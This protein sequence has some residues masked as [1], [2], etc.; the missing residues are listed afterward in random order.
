MWIDEATLK[1]QSGRGGDGIISFRHE[2]G[3]EFGGPNG[4]DGGAGGSVIFRSNETLSSLVGL[5]G[6]K[7]VKAGPGERGGATNKS[8][9]DGEDI[10]V[11]VPVGTVI[12][13]ASDGAVIADLSTPGDECMVAR[14]GR[15]GRGNARFAGPINQAPR[16]RELGEHGAALEIRLEVRLLADV[17]LVGLPNAGKSTLLSRLSAARPRIADY[18][19]TTLE[20]ML[21]VVSVGLKSFTMADLPGLIRGAHQGRGLGTRFLRHI[22]RTRLLLHLVDATSENPREDY[23]A[24]REELELYGHGLA[25]KTSLVVFTKIDAAS[26][27]KIGVK[28]PHAIS[29]HAG[30]GLDELKYAVLAALERIPAPPPLRAEVMPELDT[31]SPVDVRLEGGVFVVEGDAVR[32]YLERRAPDDRHGWRRFWQ[33]LVRWGVA[34]QLK[35]KG[36]AEGD[37]VRIGDREFEYFDEDGR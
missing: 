27:P 1:V 15:G 9:R 8:G 2:K 6:R 21:G 20:P 26:P 34:E 17:G 10:V 13:R 7:S 37:T 11:D 36:I 23:E 24:I 22:E 14:G 32:R 16:Y 4:G 18:P 25:E 31:V 12:R 19:F 3:A 35:R 29:A 28:K 5:R 30:K 33:T